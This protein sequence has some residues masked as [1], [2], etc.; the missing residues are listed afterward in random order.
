MADDVD[1]G[2]YDSDYPSHWY[3]QDWIGYDGILYC[4]IEVFHVVIDVHIVN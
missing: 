4:N 3:A 1:E 2:D